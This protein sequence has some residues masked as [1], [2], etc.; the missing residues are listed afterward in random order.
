MFLTAEQNAAGAWASAITKAKA[1]V[2]QMTTEEKASPAARILN[3]FKDLSD[4]CDI[5]Q[6]D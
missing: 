3:L 5:G 2:S 6:Y 1:L 4:K